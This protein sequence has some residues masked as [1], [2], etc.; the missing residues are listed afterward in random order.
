MRKDLAAES[1][2]YFIPDLIESAEIDV[3]DFPA[4]YADEV[5]VVSAVGA[6]VVVQL[7]V[8]VDYLRDH[9]H[10]GQFFQIAVD[11]GKADAAERLLQ[12]LPHFF[13][14]GV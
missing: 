1:L 12:L 5:M 7:A 8:R 13:R 14:A 4:G 2:R 11:S 3:L 6:E 9:P 10:S